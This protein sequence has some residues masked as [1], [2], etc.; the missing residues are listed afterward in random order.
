MFLSANVWSKD[1]YFYFA[2]VTDTHIGAEGYYDRLE[3]AL[4]AINYSSLEPKFIAVTGDITNEVIDDAK[5]EDM[6]KS[7]ELFKK[8]GLP[9]HFLPGNHDIKPDRLEPMLK[10]YKKYFG[11]VPSKAEY[12]GVVFL[13]FYIEPMINNFTIP[14]YEPMQW[15]ENELKAAKGKPVVIFQ[16]NPFSGDFYNN[17]LHAV[18]SAELREQ[19]TKLLNSYDVKA[20]ITGHFHRDELHWV[21]NVPLYVSAPVIGHWGRQ[22]TYRVYEY[23]NGKIGYRTQY[24]EMK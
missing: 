10:A 23:N 1:V 5:N 21:G 9:V 7:S 14:G 17:T 11:P 8:S 24:L 13:F 15:L 22:N 4:R 19:W 6:R 2:Q 20:V 18:G 3:Y 16:H 12:E